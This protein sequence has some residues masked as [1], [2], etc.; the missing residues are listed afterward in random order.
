MN[1]LLSDSEWESSSESGSSE[2]QEE[3]DFLFGGQAAHILS[4]LEES[5]GKI[6]DFLSFDRGFTH[7]DMVCSVTDPSGQMGRVININLLVDLE[8]IHGNI[9]RDVNCKNILKIRSIS[10]GDYVVHG[11]WLGRVDKVVDSVTIVFDDGS[12]CEVIATDQEKLLP[13]FTNLLEDSQYPYY[14]GQRVRVRPSNVSKS[15]KWL[16]GAWRESQV[17]GTVCEVDAGLVYVDWLASAL[18][19][20]DL[21]VAAP[22]HL[23][24]SKNLTLL[25]GFSHA[26]WQLGDWCM[27][28]T[29]DCKVSMEPTF[30]NSSTGNYK[31]LEKR[32]LK[33]GNL[34]SNLAEIFVIVKTKSTV[35]VLWQDGSCSLD[36]DSQTLLPVSVVNSHEFW[37]GQFVLEKDISDDP[38]ISNGQRWGVVRGVDANEKTVRVQWT[39]AMNEATDSDIDQTE[40]TLSAYE[41]VEHPD[42]SYCYGDVVFKL[43]QNQF[44]IGKEE[45]LEGKNCD[46]DQNDFPDKNYPSCIGIVIGFKDG[47]VEVRWATGFKTKVCHT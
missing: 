12:K 10:V 31:K 19:G 20:C 2:G 7:G 6:D 42:F 40:E 15:V 45:D 4:S 37:P 13:V 44:G 14:P 21:N 36:L 35:D 46:W 27:L 30:I 18:M 25:S 22:S 43:A 28:P 5:I 9:I 29:A 11:A 16:C 33:R 41:L 3:I 34:S 26:N 38:H 8:N 39:K 24:N 23:Q 17:E 32:G 47:A 1:I